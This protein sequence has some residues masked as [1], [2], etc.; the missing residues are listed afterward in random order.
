MTTE[1]RKNLLELNG[2]YTE[3]FKSL[4][5]KLIQIIKNELKKN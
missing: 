5:D 2:T 1:T 3:T 4:V